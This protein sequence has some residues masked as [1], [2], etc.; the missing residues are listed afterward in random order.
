MFV[1]SVTWLVFYRP[2]FDSMR[3]ELRMKSKIG[4]RGGG[5]NGDGEQVETYRGAVSVENSHLRRRQEANGY[6]NGEAKEGVPGKIT[7]F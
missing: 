5:A 4:N 7:K 3:V 1:L 6:T 2:Q